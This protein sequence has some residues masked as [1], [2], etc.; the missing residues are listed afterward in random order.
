MYVWHIDSDFACEEPTDYVVVPTVQASESVSGG[1]AK[2]E[3]SLLLNV[4][5][6]RVDSKLEEQ[7]QEKRVWT[8]HRK[9]E[10]V[11]VPESRVIFR[12]DRLAAFYFS[13]AALLLP[14]W[15]FL[16][17]S[18]PLLEHLSSLL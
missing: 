5:L 7:I 13:F 15:P 10:G 3:R 14:F 4:T 6:I 16:R 1:A 9:V 2:V 18:L 12:L 17:A 8:S 11:L